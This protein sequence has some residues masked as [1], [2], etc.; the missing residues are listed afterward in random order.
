MDLAHPF[1]HS[2]QV[3]DTHLFDFPH[4]DTW[5][6]LSC[7]KG[8]NILLILMVYDIILIEFSVN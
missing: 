8:T 4:N 7:E 5:Y 2:Y 6:M 1:P 3:Q